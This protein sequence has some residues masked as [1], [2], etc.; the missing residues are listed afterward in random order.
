MAKS[1][2]EKLTDTVERIRRTVYDLP[3][4]HFDET[5]IRVDKTL[6]WVHNAFSDLFTYLKC[7]VVSGPKKAQIHLRQSCLISALPISME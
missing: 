7:P 6:H 1:C 5:G 3:H 2:G 4:A